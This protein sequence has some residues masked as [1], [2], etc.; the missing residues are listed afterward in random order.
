MAIQSDWYRIAGL[1][2]QEDGT[3]AVVWAAHD[4]TTD[5]VHLYDCALFKRE[6]LAVIAEGIN[7][8][9]RWIP[10]CWNREAK[11]IADK[12]LERGVNMMPEHV[13]SS[14]PAIEAASLEIWERM[15]SHR[16]KV[17]KRLGEWLEEYRTF[18]RQDR[19]VPTDTHPLM[20]ATRHAVAQL[21]YARRQSMRR[22][23]TTNYPKVAMV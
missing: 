2:V 11:E 18:Y 6:V 12:L 13:E 16:F 23:A 21:D 10:V 5:I 8:R 4:K 19:K 1:Q 15:R 9:G 17:D 20:A 3:T 14:Q 22:G 7:A